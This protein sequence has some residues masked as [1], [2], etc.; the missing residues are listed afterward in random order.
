MNQFLLF[1]SNEALHA[2]EIE[3][4]GEIGGSLMEGD[5]QEIISA[6]RCFYSR[7]EEER[8]SIRFKN[9]IIN[10]AEVLDLARVDEVYDKP[11]FFKN[12]PIY[13]VGIFSGRIAI[14]LKLD[15]VI[16]YCQKRGK[17]HGR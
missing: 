7:E 11:S 8:H 9:F 10:V 12:V 14:L 17:N 13:G 16:E 15:E 3:G 2:V 1:K 5:N 6:A 4:V